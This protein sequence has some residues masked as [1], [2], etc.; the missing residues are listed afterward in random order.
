MSITKYENVKSGGFFCNE[1]EKHVISGI[2]DS[3]I[4]VVRIMISSLMRCGIRTHLG[5]YV[6]AE[7]ETNSSKDWNWGKSSTLSSRELDECF[8]ERAAAYVC[9]CVQ[10]RSWFGLIIRMKGWEEG[11]VLVLASLSIQSKSF[12]F[13]SGRSEERKDAFET[14][15]CQPN[16]LCLGGSLPKFSEFNSAPAKLNT[17]IIVFSFSS[18]SPPHYMNQTGGPTV[19]GRAKA[20]HFLGS[21]MWVL[22][23]CGA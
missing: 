19:S 11:F 20:C 22:W 8:V 1:K 14:V 13:T 23:E 21:L 4:I 12:I 2:F 15:L 3:L 17:L 16:F 18:Q 10:V 7:D 6:S 9:R 5:K